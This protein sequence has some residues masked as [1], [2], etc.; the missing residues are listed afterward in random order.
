MLGPSII[1]PLRDLDPPPQLTSEWSRRVFAWSMDLKNVLAVCLGYV[2]FV[3]LANSLNR[4]RSS[5]AP[6]ATKGSAPKNYQPST[7]KVWSAL[8]YFILAHNL[9]LSIFSLVVFVGMARSMWLNFSRDV[10]FMHAFCDKDGWWGAHGAANYW[11]WIFYMSKYYE[12]MDTMILLAKG[13]QSSFLQTF[14]HS[15][16]I[17][18]MWMQSSSQLAFGWIFTLFNSFIHTIMYIYYA[19]TC[20]GFRP[21]WK[22]LLTRMQ[23]AQFCIGDPIGFIYIYTPGCHPPGDYVVEILPGLS[24]QMLRYRYVSG[25]ITAA[26][27]VFLILLF[28][29]FSKKT[30]GPVTG[31]ATAKVKG[32]SAKTDVD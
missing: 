32:D 26:F 21:K 12:V 24:M 6:P 4:R 9:G 3:Q 31:A 29:D 1:T 15:G 8:D 2:L 27:V 28:V 14:H 22:Q 7:K 10:D 19:L 11:I 30:Y 18:T 16:S 20:L 17:L 25:Y 23:I 13:R 5:T